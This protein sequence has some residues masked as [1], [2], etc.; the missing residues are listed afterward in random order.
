MSLFEKASR[1]KLRF[2]SPKGQLTVED[3]WNLPLSSKSGAANLDDIARGLHRLLKD[4]ANVSFVDTAKPVDDS[5]NQLKF[6]LVKHVIDTRL[7]EQKAEADARSK[8]AQKLRILEIMENKKN[9]KLENSSM[10]ELQAMLAS[11]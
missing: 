1:L 10:E 7:I 9:T 6:D 8:A 2:D 5:A 3:L 4:D 11:L